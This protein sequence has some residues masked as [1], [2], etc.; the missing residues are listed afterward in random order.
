MV[1]VETAPSPTSNTPNLPSAGLIDAACVTAE[2]YIIRKMLKLFRR[3]LPE[4]ETAVAMVGPR[5]GDALLFLGATDL[6]LAGRAGAI[7]GLNGRTTIVDQTTGLSARIEAVG[8][9]HGALLEHVNAPFGQLPFE[10]DTFDVAIVPNLAAW[11]ADERLS[12][13]SE[14]LRVIRLAGRLILVVPAAQ[15]RLFLGGG[16]PAITDEE[17]MMLLTRLGTVANRKLAR[18]ERASYFEARKPRSI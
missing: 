9:K 1:V 10:T 8:G 4:R 3:A 5:P 7:A 2:N 12:R 6:D 11:P 15:S 16:A 17:V 13:L 14:A 18:V